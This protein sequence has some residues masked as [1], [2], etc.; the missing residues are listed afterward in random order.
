MARADAGRLP[1]RDATVDTVVMSMALM[2]VPLAEALREIRRVLK[3]GGMLIATL[4]ASSPLGVRD[5]LRW[6][7]LLLALRQ[8]GLSYPHDVSP[9]QLEQQGLVVESDDRRSF[10]FAV[11]AASDADLLVDSLYLPDVDAERL[12]AARSIAHGW[13]GKSVS[14]PLRRVVAHRHD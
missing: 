2:L 14:I 4:P 1:L 12:A 10:S 8:R 13:I 6:G 3:P 11:R 7:R 9:G 5:A